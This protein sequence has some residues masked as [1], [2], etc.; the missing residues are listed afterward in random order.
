MVPDF[1]TA[2]LGVQ[3]PVWRNVS[4]PENS[5]R[6]ADLLAVT[7]ALSSHSER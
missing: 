4:G 1:S 5:S 6:P 3:S 7:S 2:P